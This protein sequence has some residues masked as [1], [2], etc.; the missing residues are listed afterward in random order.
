MKRQRNRL[1]I[2]LTVGAILGGQQSHAMQPNVI[3]SEQQNDGTTL[4]YAEI[5]EGSFTDPDSQNFS[6][7]LS[8]ARNTETSKRINFFVH[9][10]LDGQTD[11]LY[12]MRYTDLR[13]KLEDCN[14]KISEEIEAPLN[15]YTISQLSCRVSKIT[16]VGTLERPYAP[17]EPVSVE[18]PFAES[19]LYFWSR[20]GKNGYRPWDW[21]ASFTLDV[22]KLRNQGLKRVSEAFEGAI[23]EDSSIPHQKCSI[24]MGT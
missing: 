8:G 5:V 11:M 12:Q 1:L 20:K 2:A 10:V 3:C 15:R 7:G 17:S 22:I 9:G 21:Q 6:F 4:K 16:A 18:L 24:N 23:F 19:S 13:V 14:K